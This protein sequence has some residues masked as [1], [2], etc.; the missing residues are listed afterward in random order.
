MFRL[1]KVPPLTNTINGKRLLHDTENSD[2][3]V[4]ISMEKNRV[5]IKKCYCKVVRSDVVFYSSMSLFQYC[6]HL[7][8]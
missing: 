6:I 8:F 3:V 4:G 5:T 1:E 2:S 7:D